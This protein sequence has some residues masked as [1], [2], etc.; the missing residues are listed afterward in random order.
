MFLLHESGLETKHLYDE[1]LAALADNLDPIDRRTMSYFDNQ[2]DSQ[3]KHAA[4]RRPVRVMFVDDHR[5]VN[6]GLVHLFKKVRSIEVVAEAEDGPAA[7][8]LARTHIPDVVVM[9]AYLPKRK[10]STAAIRTIIAENRSVQVLV[11][12]SAFSPVDIREM[13]SAGAMG[14]VT[15][16][17][18]V[19]EIEQAV[20]AV[21]A[22]RR[23]FCQTAAASLADETTD[24]SSDTAFSSLTSRE[25]EIFLALAEGKDTG[26]IALLFHISPD[27]VAT[28][29]RNIFQKM[30]L[31]SVPEL[32]WYAVEHRLVSA[33]Q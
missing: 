25:Q 21:F 9:D 17:C 13:L 26:Q 2:I 19:E 10:D 32:I 24:L 14:Y 18:S 6:Q 8:R 7:V 33:S 31:R 29:R 11:L 16:N 1:N 3:K 30:K 4:S 27:T 12:S 23:Y 22:G 15:K 28:H 20:L 5:C